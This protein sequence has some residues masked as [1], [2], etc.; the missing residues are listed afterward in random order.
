MKKIVLYFGDVFWCTTP[1]VGLSLFYELSNYFEVIPVFSKNDIRLHKTWNGNESFW[2]DK[3]KFLDLP[4]IETDDLVKT[5]ESINP[6]LFLLSAQMQFKP[7]FASRNRR[8]KD[9]GVKIGMW[10]VGGADAFWCDSETSGWDYFFSK[11]SAWKKAMSNITE[12]KT[13]VPIIPIES[14]AEKNIFVTGCLDFDD[15]PASIS[16]STSETDDSKD[17]FCKKYNLDASKPI[18]A[19]I[20]ANPAPDNSWTYPVTG[21]SAL[22]ALN[23]I[24][25]NLYKLKERGYQVCIKSHPNDYISSETQGSYFGVHPRAQRGGYNKERFK[26]DRYKGFT[27]IEAQD[28]YSLYSVCEFG[29]TNY[30]HAG[31]EL[32]ISGKKCFSYRMEECPEWNYVEDLCEKVYID[33]STGDDMLNII[34]ESNILSM[35]LNQDYKNSI[36][37]FFNGNSGTAYKHITEKLIEI[38]LNS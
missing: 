13:L 21:I 11:G 8:I 32:F 16:L 31:Y 18:I 33:V 20:P 29:V 7:Q 14:Q 19:Y 4:F 12:L 35:D 10:D 1:Y 9:L 28:G 15:I 22:H 36:S 30:S 34:T 37:Y 5:V 27:I 25:E 17:V 23:D 38:L 24:N 26:D 6:D 3:S 2:F